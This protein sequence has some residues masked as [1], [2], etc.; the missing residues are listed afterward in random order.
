MLRL[1]VL[2]SGSGSNLQSILDN[3]KSGYL[4]AEV[5]VVISSKAGVYALERAKTQHSGNCG[6][7]K[8]V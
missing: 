3:I 6:N 1:G 8:E 5:V 4:P 2:V 7:T